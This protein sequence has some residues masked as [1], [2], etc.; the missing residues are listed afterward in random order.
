LIDDI[1]EL[2]ELKEFEDSKDKEKLLIIDDFIAL[3][4][5]DMKK[6]EKY[7]ISSRKFGFTVI[8]M[9]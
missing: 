4:S 3:N 6:I 5:K 9:S 8:V 1:N 7:L 2:P